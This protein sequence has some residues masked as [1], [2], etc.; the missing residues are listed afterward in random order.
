MRRCIRTKSIGICDSNDMKKIP[1][2]KIEKMIPNYLANNLGNYDLVRF[3]NHIEGC[4]ECK[5]E[6]SIQF[7]ISEGLNTLTD[8]ESFNLQ[9]AFDEQLRRSKRY[10]ALFKKLRIARNTAIVVV[11][12]AI[13][14]CI[15]LAHLYVLL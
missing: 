7:L 1:C 4:P 8:G 15:Y 13:I 3:M 2:K 9:E 11:V 14:V 6:L 10:I 5:E 12:L